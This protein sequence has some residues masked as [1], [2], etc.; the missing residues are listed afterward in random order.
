MKMDP[1][2]RK[3]LTWTTNADPSMSLEFSAD[4][5]NWTPVTLVAGEVE[6]LLRGP[7]A[8]AYVGAVDVPLGRHTLRMKVTDNPEIE[9]DPLG[10]LIVE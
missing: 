6:V 7:D 9:I 5:V 4:N 3:Y 2:E 10:T 8:P 1:R